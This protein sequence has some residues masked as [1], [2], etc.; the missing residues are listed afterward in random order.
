M[1]LNED[2]GAPVRDVG[3]QRGCAVEDG[4]PCVPEVLAAVVEIDDV[5]GVVAFLA[6]KQ[7]L[8]FAAPPVLSELG[9]FG[10]VIRPLTGLHW[11]AQTDASLHRSL[12]GLRRCC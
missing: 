1:F 11:L 12:R 7:T 3:G 4:F 5:D 10:A 2:V 9:V 6:G 8:H